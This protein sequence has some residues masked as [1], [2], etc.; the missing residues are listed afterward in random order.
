M[1]MT[2]HT[3]TFPANYFPA[4]YC[5][6]GRTT[7][8]SICS[9]LL[10]ILYLP[11]PLHLP[12]LPFVMSHSTPRSPSYLPCVS[13]SKMK[14]KAQY[15]RNQKMSYSD[16]EAHGLLGLDEMDSR[17]A[18]NSKLKLTHHQSDIDY[19]LSIL[20]RVVCVST[21]EEVCIFIFIYFCSFF[22]V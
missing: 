17:D 19:I 5:G 7:E 16:F 18:N 8:R 22:E 11:L 10:T 1:S 21:Q 9:G 6:Q 3:A 12:L 15:P 14:E 20:V 13:T 4:Q 2:T